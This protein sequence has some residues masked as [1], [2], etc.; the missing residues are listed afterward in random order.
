[1]RKTQ[2]LNRPQLRAS[3]AISNVCEIN[4]S[5]TSASRRS[6]GSRFGNG[7]IRKSR[8]R[9]AGR[10][11]CALFGSRADC[12]LR[13]STADKTVTWQE[14]ERFCKQPN[15]KPVL[16][17]F[18]AATPSTRA[19]RRRFMKEW[20]A[21][22]EKKRD[23]TLG[24]TDPASRPVRPLDD[25]KDIDDLQRILIEQFNRNLGSVYSG[26]RNLRHQNRKSL[27]CERSAHQPIPDISNALHSV[28]R[29]ICG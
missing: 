13:L 27:K 25:Y 4:G 1:M 8:S 20:L 16:V 18:C 23:L 29:S 7:R 17:L 24:W 19:S 15:A 10:S 14:L 28:P 9:G 3:N 2:S 11:N 6:P 5:G 21:V 22:L 12:N 26:L